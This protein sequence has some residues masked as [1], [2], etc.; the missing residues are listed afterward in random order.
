MVKS[1]RGLVALGFVFGLCLA[2]LPATTG[3]ASG[4]TW[5]SLAPMNQAAYG[6]SAGTL[7]NGEVIAAGGVAWPHGGNP[8]WLNAAEIYDP[9]SNSWSPTTPMPQPTAI[10]GSAVG[11]DGKFYVFGGESKEDLYLS[12]LQI[13]DPSTQT[14]TVG[15]P[16]PI[17]VRYV[18]G[19]ALLNGDIVAI[20]GGAFNG[21]IFIGDV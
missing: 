11:T 16:M 17:A 10:A 14:W 15:P 1:I 9:N 18:S 12:T 4:P 5:H 20:G 13:F 21:G 3:Q 19:A 6:E 2:L 8:Q 7:D